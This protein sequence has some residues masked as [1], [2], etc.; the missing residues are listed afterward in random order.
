[1]SAA[2]KALLRCNNDTY[3]FNGVYLF[4]RSLVFSSAWF[5]K[6][7]SNPGFSLS[8]CI[9]ILEFWCNWNF[10]K[11]W[12]IFN[13]LSEIIWKFYQFLTE[14]EYILIKFTKVWKKIRVQILLA[15]RGG[16]KITKISKN[17]NRNWNPWSTLAQTH[18]CLI[19]K[20]ISKLVGRLVN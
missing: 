5:F 11:F 1:M 20:T 19:R 12:E 10:Q 2:C 3:P 9:E 13:F 4:C 14:F 15:G 18:I 6:K 16:G 8:V 17:L 7:L